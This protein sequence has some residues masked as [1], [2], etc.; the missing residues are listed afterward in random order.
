MTVF[1]SGVERYLHVNKI[2]QR[3]EALT[4][5]TVASTAITRMGEIKKSGPVTNQKHHGGTC[6]M[7]PLPLPRPRPRPHRPRPL[8]LIKSNSLC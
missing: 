1:P 5:G 8:P 6:A 3:T 2:N 4:S 7:H